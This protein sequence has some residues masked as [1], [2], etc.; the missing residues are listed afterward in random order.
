MSYSVMAARLVL[1]Q[2]ILVRPQLGQQMI[3]MSFGVIGNTSDFGSEESRFEP[4]WD[5]IKK[6]KEWLQ[7]INKHQTFTLNRTYHSVIWECARVGELGQT[8]IR[9]LDW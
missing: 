6:N 7:Q 4:W 9:A 3:I 1:S 5:N 8:V 2:E